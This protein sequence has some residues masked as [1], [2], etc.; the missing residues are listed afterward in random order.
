MGYWEN[1]QAHEMYGAMQDAEAAAQEIADIY[2]KASRE[3]NYKIQKI[4]DRYVDKFDLS[5]DEAEKLLNT[6][7]SS[8]D[9]QDL[10][11]KLEG[12]KGAARQEILKELES[13]AYRARIERLQNLQQEI[14]A[15]MKDV[16]LQEK[17]VHTNHYV[18]QFHNAYYQEIYDLQKRVGFQFSFS[19]VDPKQLNRILNMNW[20]GSNY[21]EKIWRNTQGV[22]RE[23]K[24]QLILA[25]LTGKPESEI[26]MELAKKYSKG[27]GIARRLIR[28]EAAYVSGQGQ[29][30]ADEECGIDQYRIL[31]TLDLRTSDRC[32]SMDG[33]VFAYKDMQVGV[34]Y[35]PFHPWCRTTVLSELDDMNLEELRRRARDPE[36]GKN[37]LVPATTTYDAWYKKNVAGKPEML[38]AE[39]IEKHRGADIAQ[40]ARYAEVL[41]KG[42]IEKIDDFRKIKYNEPE[43]YEYIKIDYARQHDLLMHPEKALPE[44]PKMNLPE[45]KFTQ[46]LFAGEN[47]RGLNHGKMFTDILGYDID[48]WQDLQKVIKKNSKKYPAKLKE[49]T[50]YGIRYEQK[51]ILYGKDGTPANVIVGW[52]QD[53]AADEMRMTSTYIKEVK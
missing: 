49:K 10:K 44:M 15:M 21:S 22:A 1:R 17:K 30:A 5:E 29:A 46:Y 3:L 32:R 8:N 43:R 27:A 36:T 9:I 24:E 42:I 35:P 53:A 52:I 50:A 19:A 34:N 38:L 39:Q 2:A 20:S 7:L 18:D 40:Y 45:G 4:F 16:Y 47:K 12:V 31:A 48:N 33:K 26:A 37:V 28:T 14:D 6:I 13:P 23:L 11:A 51:M 25:Y 41:G